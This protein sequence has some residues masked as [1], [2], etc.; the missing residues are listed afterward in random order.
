MRALLV[1]LLV[2][3]PAVA[4]PPQ[5]RVSML[6]VSEERTG[7]LSIV[8][9]EAP[10]ARGPVSV[11]VVAGAR[12]RLFLRTSQAETGTVHEAWL[13]ARPGLAVNRDG[14]GML[15][16]DSGGITLRLREDDLGLRTVRCWIGAL[17]S[18]VEPRLLTAAADVR[19]VKTALGMDRLGAD[20]LPMRLL[21][22][23]DEEPSVT[24]QGAPKTE[25]GPF[26][27]AP[28][29]DL[30]RAAREELGKP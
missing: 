17:A 21:W 8:R 30:L 15:Q 27:G 20:F 29:D 10:T 13:D 1:A 28:W 11:T 14:S 7:S 4:E 24:L 3:L 9:L 23:L 22:A 2:A 26:E 19:A 18:R 5:E 12:S 25:E 6:R 16:L